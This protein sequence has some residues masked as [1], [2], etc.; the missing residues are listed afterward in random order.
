MNKFCKF[1]GHKFK[2]QKSIIFL[3]F[4]NEHCNNKFF[5]KNYSI[6]NSIKKNK[7]LRDKFNKRGVRCMLKTTK[8]F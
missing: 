3:Y 6:Y 1:A 5:K 8:R 4:R 7:I 2:M